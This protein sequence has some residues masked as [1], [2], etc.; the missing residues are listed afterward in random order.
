[1]TATAG[2]SF[3]IKKC[4]L[5]LSPADSQWAGE[6]PLL[7]GGQNYCWLNQPQT[8][9]NKSKGCSSGIV[10][11][12]SRRTEKGSFL[13]THFEV[14]LIEIND[15]VRNKLLQQWKQIL[16][17]WKSPLL[18]KTVMLII[19]TV[20]LQLFLFIGKYIFFIY[21][22]IVIFAPWMGEQYFMNSLIQ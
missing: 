6:N 12:N 7:L 13:S 2:Y 3:C 10:S 9:I 16:S 21:R 19:N 18:P 17:I 22:N 11:I 5:L 15:W 8:E 1:M 4:F 14:Q 20:I